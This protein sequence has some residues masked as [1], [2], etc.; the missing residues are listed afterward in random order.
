MG[1]KQTVIDALEHRQPERTPHYIELTA[2]EHERVA[3]YLGRD[4]FAADFDNDLF[5]AGY[6][7]QSVPIDGRPNFFRDDWG[8]VWDRN[9]IDKDIG[10]P[11]SP[12]VHE[13]DPKTEFR[14]AIDEAWMDSLFA[15]LDRAPADTFRIAAHGFSMFERAWILRGME[16]LLV[17]MLDEPEFVDAFLDKICEWDLR[18][19]EIGLRHNPDAFLFGDDW[20]Q[21]KGMIMGPELW[22]RFIKPR[23]ARLYGRVREAGKYVLQHSCGD[24]HE[25]FPDL[26][27]IGLN[28]YQTVQPEIYDL[29]AIKHEFGDRLAFWGGI[30]TQKL[31]PFATPA[32]VKQK[33][34]ETVAIMAPGGGYI[35]APTHAVPGD[36]PAENILALSEAFKEI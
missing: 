25:V 29:R 35:A 1:K 16:N 36:V 24:I 30:S 13:P 8:T 34:A 21:Q 12:L 7:G 10:V 28:A 2:Q 4:D 32:E 27:E 3:Q 18:V 14:P 17:D 23:M 9:G 22:R 6:N 19:I 31:L 15:P 11:T 26:I 5:V 33:V 20:G